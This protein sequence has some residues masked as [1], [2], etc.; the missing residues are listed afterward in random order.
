MC[1]GEGVGLV[2]EEKWSIFKTHAMDKE[3]QPCNLCNI[4][5]VGYPATPSLK[6]HLEMDYL[7]TKIK[8]VSGDYLMYVVDGPT[9]SDGRSRYWLCR[10]CA[11]KVGVIW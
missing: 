10:E 11:R 8:E 4:V 1:K 5:I 2:K 3:F 9:K 7:R 6:K